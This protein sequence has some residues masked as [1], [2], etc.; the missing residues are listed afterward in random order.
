MGLRKPAGAWQCRNKHC[1]TTGHSCERRSGR[2]EEV[3]DVSERRQASRRGIS[4][5]RPALWLLLLAAALPLAAAQARPLELG[6]VD[7]ENSQYLSTDVLKSHFGTYRA[8]GVTS[9]RAPVSWSDQ[10]VAPGQWRD[11]T[12]LGYMRLA[13]AA[14]LR[15]GLDLETIAAPP[16]WFIAAHPDARLVDQN[17]ATTGTQMI[18]YWYPGLHELVH[19]QADRILAMLQARG[20]LADISTV[21]AS[22]GPADEPIYPPQWVLGPGAAPPGFWWFD[23]HASADFPRAM[24]AKYGT[25]AA[26]NAAWGTQYASWSAVAP[27]RPGAAAGRLWADTLDWYRDAKRDF[28]RWQVAD[29]TALVHKY[30][31]ADP[32]TVAIPV[33]GTHLPPA[34]WQQALHSASSA[35]PLI[36]QMNDTDMLIDVATA[37]GASLHFTGMPAG[38][39]LQYIR[40]RLRQTGSRARL[41][42]ETVSAAIL[43]AYADDLA[44]EVDGSSLDGFDYLYGTALFGP[45]HLTPSA[46]MAPVAGMLRRLAGTADPSRTTLAIPVNF[47]LVQGGCVDVA[48]A[49]ATRLCLS[50]TGQLALQRGATTLWAAPAPAQSCP[51]G[52]VWTMSCR[53]SFQGDGNLVLYDA[54]TPYWNTAT[55]GSQAVTLQAHA[56]PPYLSLL[57]AAGAVVWSSGP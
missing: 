30:W 13:A 47:N 57:T 40:A 55:G 28:V 27:P 50:A 48:P 56:A 41:T 29:T 34:E 17:G 10:E 44:A 32:P 3:C 46:D 14:G 23:V 15:L 2:G 38:E 43:A 53:A 42:G 5:L 6:L 8:L 49:S 36:V 20:V 7:A 25:V 9:V 26:A 4:R 18:S 12:W 16:A 33:P 54:A 24:A 39:E 22:L 11:A 1:I 37:N 45:D 31:P 35:D 51:T 52:Q 19:G 21:V